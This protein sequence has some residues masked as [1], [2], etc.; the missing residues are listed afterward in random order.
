MSIVKSFDTCMKISS[1]PAEILTSFDTRM[2]IS[3]GS[4]PS[5]NLI[6]LTCFLEWRACRACLIT[7]YVQL[8]EANEK[9]VST[10]IRSVRDKHWRPN[11]DTRE[12]G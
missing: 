4:R 2:K 5:V 7:T 8:E 12:S 9:T 11:A 6:A 1:Q 10:G 3:S